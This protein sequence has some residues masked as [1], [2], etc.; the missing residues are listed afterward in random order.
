MLIQISLKLV[1]Q[2]P[3][4]NKFRSCVINLVPSTRQTITWMN[5]LSHC[6]SQSWTVFVKFRL[7]ISDLEYVL[8]RILWFHQ[9][10]ASP[11][12]NK[13]HIPDR[14]KLKIRRTSKAYFDN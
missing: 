11:K 14:D 9:A 12:I 13:E 4:D 6:G 2:D 7:V 10:R 1:S 8:R 3:N 5:D